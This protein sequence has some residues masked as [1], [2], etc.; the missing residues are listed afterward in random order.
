MQYV[1]MAI[2][3]CKQVAACLP[4]IVAMQFKIILIDNAIHYINYRVNTI[5]FIILILSLKLLSMDMYCGLC[6][7]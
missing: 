6:L 2:A 5:N 3:I 7:Y 4:D 1:I